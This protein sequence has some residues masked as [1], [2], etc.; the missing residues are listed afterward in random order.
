M[1]SSDLTKIE[2]C[3]PAYKELFIKTVLRTLCEADTVGTPFSEIHVLLQK[4][5]SYILGEF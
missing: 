5:Q 1:T 3:L 2:E 4:A